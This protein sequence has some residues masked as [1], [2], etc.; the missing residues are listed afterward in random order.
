VDL[1]EGRKEQL[2][3][4]DG[5]DS[6]RYR[7]RLQSERI[8]EEHSGVWRQRRWCKFSSDTDSRGWKATICEGRW[9]RFRR[10]QSVTTV[11]E[12]M[13]RILWCLASRD[14]GDG[15]NPGA[16]LIQGDDV[17]GPKVMIGEGRLCGFRRIPRL[18]S[19]RI[20]EEHSSVCH[21]ATEAMVK[22]LQRMAMLI[23]GD[24]VRT[25][26]IRSP[27]WLII[28]DD[29]HQMAPKNNDQIL[30]EFNRSFS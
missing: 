3:R 8:W 29:N 16:M 23:Q 15:E 24:D 22:T 5:V 20:W 21:L 19:D 27:C 18:Q 12:N 6:G 14:R 28:R 13:G 11:R 26:V 2:A 30:H 17:R 7:A 1:R 9:C 4:D 25:S 10:I